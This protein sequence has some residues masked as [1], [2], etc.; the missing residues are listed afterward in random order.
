MTLDLRDIFAII[1]KRLLFIIT[2]TLLCTLASAIFSFFVIK[3]TYQTDTSFVIGKIADAGKNN[4]SDFTMYQ[5]L[6]K[7]YAA[8]ASSNSVAQ[9]ASNKLGIDTKTFIKSITVTPEVDTQ[10]LDIKVLAASP[11]QAYANI[12]TLSNSFI[13]QAKKIYPTGDIGVM[14]KPVLPDKPIK[15][16]KTLNIAIAF[17]IGLMVSIG[18]VFVLKNSDKTI[19][20]EEEVEHYISKENNSIKNIEL[21]IIEIKNQISE[22]KNR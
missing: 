19:K 9:D 8:I 11:E 14:D 16:N 15:P 20:T 10:I 7:T 2:I 18:L 12:N 17:F 6:V 1:R 4:S 13:A 5:Q 22:I 3:P 21:N